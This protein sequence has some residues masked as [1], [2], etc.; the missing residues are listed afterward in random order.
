VKALSVLPLVAALAWSQPVKSVWIRSQVP[1][2]ATPAVARLLP[3][4]HSVEFTPSEVI[5]R[6]AGIS[7]AYLGPLEKAPQPKNEVS[8]LAFH[9]PLHPQAETG[10]HAHIPQLYGGV[11]VNGVPVY[12]HF[13][14]ASYRGQNLWHYDLMARPSTD[15]PSQPGLLEKLIPARGRHSPLIGFALD[16]FPIY[17]PWGDGPARMRSSYQLRQISSRDIL[18]NGLLLAPGQAGPPVNAEYPLGSFVEDYEYVAGSGDLDQYNGRFA[19]TPEYPEGTYAYFLATSP[20]GK[21]AFPYLLAHEFYGRYQ[22][23]APLKADERQISF[24]FAAPPQAGQ[25]ASLQFQVF[26]PKGQPIRHLEH[27][28]ERPIHLLIVSPDLA[29]F[30]HIHPE[31]DEYGVWQVKH[32]FGHG[33]KYRLYAD[34]TPPGSKQRVEAFD[35]EIG[36]PRRSPLPLSAAAPKVPVVFENAKSLRAG[37][38]LELHFALQLSAHEPYLGAWAHV[39]IAG[40]NFSSFLHAHPIEGQVHEHEAHGPPPTLLR[41]AAV[42]PQAGRYKLWLQVQVAGRVETIPFVVDV[43]PAASPVTVSA[44][45]S[46]AIRVKINP[47]GYE[48]MCV[49]IPAGKPVKIAFERSAQSNCGGK[50]VFPALGLSK[51]VPLGGSALFDLPAQPA[52]EYRFTCGMGMYR[53]SI[54]AAP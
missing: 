5:V 7:L 39:V 13:E 40:E 29:E 26:D 44:L 12:N 47:D 1:A 28:H 49:A 45:P 34:L 24:R 20:E 4:V 31:V 46:D 16:G 11:F 53:G 19:R 21:I 54:V 30:E 23:P 18:P 6:S 8:E 3:D 32:R 52:G 22:S 38:D 41:V 10:V 14:A 43:A 2:G 17:G 36:G 42:F 9:L 37:Q 51:E 27:V 25:E 15:H 48:P 33:G 35:V 50:V